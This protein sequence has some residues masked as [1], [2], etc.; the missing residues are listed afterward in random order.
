MVL[1]PSVASWTWTKQSEKRLL[2]EAAHLRVQAEHERSIAGHTLSG[3]SVYRERADSLR[4]Q[5]EELER[6]AGVFP[7]SYPPPPPPP[8]RPLRR[9]AHDAARHSRQFAPEDD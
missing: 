9:L 5:A 3:G 6:R 4:S 8:P 1:I 2:A 7:S